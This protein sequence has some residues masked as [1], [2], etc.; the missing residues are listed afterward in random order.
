MGFLLRSVLRYMLELSMFF[1]LS[2]E[3]LWQWLFECSTL[4]LMIRDVRDR[5][6][7]NYTL[8][9]PGPK[10]KLYRDQNRDRKKITGT[11]TNA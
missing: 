7:K 8:Q 11:G 6:Q 1:S 5:D 9:G 2:I 3:D 10:E 4:I